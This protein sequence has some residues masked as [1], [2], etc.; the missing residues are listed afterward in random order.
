MPATLRWQRSTA[1][2]R[3]CSGDGLHRD[4]VHRDADAL[5]EH[6]GR[7]AHAARFIDDI[8]CRRALDDLVAFERAVRAAVGQQR[9]QMRVGHQC[10][11]E[12]HRGARVDADRLAAIAREIMTFWMRVSAWFSAAATASRID[13]SAWSMLMTVPDL[14]PWLSRSAAPRTRRLPCSARPMRQTVL[15]EPTSSAAIRP[16]AIRRALR[17]PLRNRTVSP[18]RL[19]SPARP[20]SV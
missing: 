4:R 10:A 18:I 20:C 12:R 13:S 5:A 11:I 17:P 8:G 7:I 9:V 3:F 2:F 15:D 14:M 1:S 19:H 16:R 6:A